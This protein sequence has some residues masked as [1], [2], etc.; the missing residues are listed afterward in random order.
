MVLAGR[1]LA[2]DIDV[3]VKL[4]DSRSGDAVTQERALREARLMARLDHPNLLR[5]H[6]AGRSGPYIFL[7]LELMDGG[8]LE[9]VRR[10]QPERVSALARQL[11]SGLQAL[12]DARILHRDLKP[13]NC[14]VRVRDGRVKLADLGL[15]IDPAASH[16]SRLAGTLPFMAPE[17][18]E[19]A[20][21]GV[22]TDLYALGLTLACFALGD[23]PY[24]AGSTAEV[25][26]WIMRGP[27]P[28]VSAERSDLPPA[29]AAAI[30]RLMAPRP[31]DRPGSASEALAALVEESRT[32]APKAV[33]TDAERIGPWVLGP[34][35][36]SSDNWHMHA[37][38]H[39]R[40]GR[41]AR[42]AW[43]Q[44]G[45]TLTG[46]SGFILDAA[47]R[48]AGLDHPGILA[49][50]DW[51]MRA[52]RAYV[53]TA[54][55][56]RTLGEL[57]ASRGALDELQALDFAAVLA[58]ALAYLH[59]QG[60]VYQMLEP[61]TAHVS[62]DAG[63][64]QLAWPVYCVPVGGSVLDAQGVAHRVV[65][66]RFAA[67]E[68]LVGSLAE[69]R[70]DPAVDLYGLGELLYYLLAGRP[71]FTGDKPMDIVLAKGRTPPDVRHVAADVTQPT[72]LLVSALLDPNPTAR[73]AGAA[74]VRSQ[75]I[76]TVERLGGPVSH[77]V[78]TRPVGGDGSR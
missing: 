42:L 16:D 70:F 52:G 19:G 35:S 50:L 26:G 32:P 37:A 15:A 11:L 9:S 41:P 14:L 18:F 29:L 43:L 67:P 56:G 3:A 77:L 12:H 22:A 47:R 59:G 66:P 2:L 40:T 71:A 39:A 78:S 74:V 58:D 46:R 64:A 45:G 73:P 61:G 24:P 54:P 55:Q 1:H 68:T 17:L 20:G 6:D 7:V 33:E 72:A 57:V 5:I 10:A 31:S 48:A 30:E 60:V 36:Y 63:G 28:R 49:V 75:L 27:R 53:V 34:L 65:N 4:I 51:G 25:L 69:A 21:F 23:R 13:A 8:S 76:R 38:T 62:P 44:H